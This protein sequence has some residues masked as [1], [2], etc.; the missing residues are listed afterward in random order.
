MQQFH[1]QCFFPFLCY[2]YP[3][4]DRYSK[5][6][7]IVGVFKWLIDKSTWKGRMIP[8]HIIHQCS[9]TC[10]WSCRENSR[11]YSH[12]QCV[13]SQWIMSDAFLNKKCNGVVS[14]TRVM[15]LD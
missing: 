10:R 4:S 1:C 9:L 7:N 14:V 3:L 15:N 8:L 12:L 11:I 2:L 13:T 5:S 6:P